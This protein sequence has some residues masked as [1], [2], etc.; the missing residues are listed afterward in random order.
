ME[1]ILNVL[2]KKKKFTQIDVFGKKRVD[3]SRIYINF[4]SEFKYL[5]LIFSSLGDDLLFTIKKW[6]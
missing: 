2:R 5:K 4:Y 3:N 6:F 1:I